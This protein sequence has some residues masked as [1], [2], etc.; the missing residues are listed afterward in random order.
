MA[1][2]AARARLLRIRTVGDQ[3]LTAE[4]VRA[5]V[6]S[7]LGFYRLHGDGRSGEL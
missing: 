2:V 7:N 1:W 4:E 3:N 6:G 5:S